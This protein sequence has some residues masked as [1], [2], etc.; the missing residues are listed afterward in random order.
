MK[1]VTIK[2]NAGVDYEV[3]NLESFHRHILKFHAS[4]ASIHE[5]N[6]HYFTVDDAFRKMIEGFI[7]S[8]G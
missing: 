8:S 2:D 4:G 1:S 7:R 3:T 5:E 6:G